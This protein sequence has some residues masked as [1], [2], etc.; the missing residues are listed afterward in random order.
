MFIAFHLAAS[1]AAATAFAWRFGHNPR[2]VVA[3]I[4]LVAE[5]DLALVT[6]MSALG[7]RVRGDELPGLNH[8][9]EVV[10][11]VREE[12]CRELVQTFFKGRR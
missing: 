1:A 12:A 2:V 10:R 9:F 6:L 4:V 7:S 11:S 3:H 8:R 5:W